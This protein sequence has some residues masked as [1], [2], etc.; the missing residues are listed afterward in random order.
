MELNTKDDL[1]KVIK[2][3]EE[4][5]NKQS[6]RLDVL[7]KHLD[8]KDSII[9]DDKENKKEEEKKEEEKPSEK[10]VDEVSKLLGV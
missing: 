10:E 2:A 8:D 5:I 6:T 7:E 4:L 9:D 3:Q 1:I